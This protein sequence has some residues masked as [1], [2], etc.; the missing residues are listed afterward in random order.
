MQSNNMTGCKVV[1][2]RWSDAIYNKC[3]DSLE[4]RQ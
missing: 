1:N 4:W 3:V 2:W